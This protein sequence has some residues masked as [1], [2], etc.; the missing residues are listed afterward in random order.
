MKLSRR[1]FLQLTAAGVVAGPLG[2][3]GPQLQESGTLAGVLDAYIDTLLPADS[4]PG[5]L[6]LGVAG[7][8]RALVHAKRALVP[9][10][11]SGIAWLEAQAQRG[12]GRGFATL[13]LTGRDALVMRLSEQSDEQLA[14][15]FHKSLRHVMMFYY[16]NPRAWDALGLAGAPQPAGFMDYAQAPGGHG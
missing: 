15:F 5:A 6:E 8:V 16:S 14:R 1:R 4:A 3:A 10:Y 12:D 13:A 11:N 2:C 9:V 7:Q